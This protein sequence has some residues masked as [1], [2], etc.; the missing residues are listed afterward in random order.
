MSMAENFARKPAAKD[1]WLSIVG[2]GEDGIEG[3][4]LPARALVESAEVVFGGA[5]HLALAARLIGGTSI[6]WRTPFD[7]ALADVLMHRGRRVC[8]LASGDPLMYGVG[9][10]LTQHVGADELR[11]IPVAS[12]FSLAA[13]RLLWA[14]NET[15][16]VSVCGRALDTLRPHLAPGARILVLTS[17]AKTPAQIAALLSGAGFGGS[18]LTVLEALG[19]PRERIRGARADSFGLEEL[20][21][22]NVV[23]LE[24]ACDTE[25]R[26]LPRSS[27]LPDEWFENDGQITKRE[28]RAATL[29][30]LSPRRG[31]L[32]WDIGAGSGSVAI[33]WLLADA[34][35]RAIAIERR[36]DR[37]ANIRKNAAMLG[38]PHLEIIEASAPAALEDLPAPHAIFIGG[39]AT[40]TGVIDRAREHLRSR[41]RLVVNAVAVQTE[42]LLIDQHALCGGT[43]TR[44]MISRAAPIGGE[45]RM[46]GWYPAMPVTQWCWVKS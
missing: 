17:D 18:K 7:A 32:L 27:G 4:S 1:P 23:A 30:A 37:A 3:L 10:R 11:V 36:A 26:I 29:S 46:S 38:V 14:L 44:I 35:L 39:G 9:A 21:S 24:V 43:L 13:A 20:D 6:A 41:G 5:R 15:Q 8:V 2:I 34:S 33:E 45:G 25:A 42:R 12:A 40:G 31:E 19:G 16:L 28:I 22:L